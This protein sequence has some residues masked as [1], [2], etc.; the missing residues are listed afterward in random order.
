[1]SPLCTLPYPL[2]LSHLHPLQ[3]GF[4]STWGQ[5]QHPK[6]LGLKRGVR[7]LKATAFTGAEVG[8]G[9]WT[10]VGRPPLSSSPSGQLVLKQHPSR[11]NHQVTGTGG[12]VRPSSV[13]GTRPPASCE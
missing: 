8:G 5:R 3:G 6:R 11:L 1:M 4:G 7:R 10:L 2:S 12:I 9:I 13:P